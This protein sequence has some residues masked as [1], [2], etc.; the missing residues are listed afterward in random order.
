[1]LT[2]TSNAA[3][4]RFALALDP[5]CARCSAAGKAIHEIVGEKRE[6]HG[7]ASSHVREWSSLSQQSSREWTPTL[8]KIDGEQTRAWTGLGFAIH[9]SGGCGLKRQGI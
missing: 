7:L 8:F 5:G 4:V 1:M 6:I 9:F 3:D 2:S